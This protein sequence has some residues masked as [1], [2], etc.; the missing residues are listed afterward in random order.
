METDGV[1]RVRCLS[2][3]TCEALGRFTSCATSHSHFSGNRKREKEI[4]FRR[5]SPRNMKAVPAQLTV[6]DNY[7]RP[8]R[9]LCSPKVRDAA[10]RK[11]T[12]G[13]FHLPH[14]KS[15]WADFLH[16]KAP[17]NINDMNFLYLRFFKCFVPRLGE[18]FFISKI[19]ID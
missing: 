1:L 6:T 10:F 5:S 17:K 16:L 11:I 7:R 3:C 4:K 13:E 15:I 18:S 2:A 8:L 9:R 19:V 14:E 12:K